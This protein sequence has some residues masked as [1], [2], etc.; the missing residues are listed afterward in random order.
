MKAWGI[1]FP[2]KLEEFGSGV[3]VLRAQLEVESGRVVRGSVS[4][5]FWWGVRF[6][7]GRTEVCMWALSRGAWNVCMWSGWREM[8]GGRVC[9]MSGG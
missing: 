2:G 1:L 7:Q 4:D 6:E 9:G 5:V 3:R 8:M